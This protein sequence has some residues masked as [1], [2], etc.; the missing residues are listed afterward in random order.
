[1]IG[2]T[3]SG[4]KDEQVP[5]DGRGEA[6]RPLKVAVRRKERPWKLKRYQKQ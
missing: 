6:P 5:P 3:L 1:M 2:Q 4:K